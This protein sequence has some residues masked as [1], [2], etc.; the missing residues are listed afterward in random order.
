MGLS[1]SIFPIS[2]LQ[3]SEDFKKYLTSLNIHGDL[4]FDIIESCSKYPSL[5]EVYQLI[6]Q[7]GIIIESENKRIDDN[8]LK[9][10]NELIIHSLYIR[11]DEDINGNDFTM[12]YPKSSTVHDEIKTLLGIKSDLRILVKLFSSLSKECGSFIILSPYD[13][14]YIDKSK[15]FGEIWGQYGFDY[16]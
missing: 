10:G 15:S 14:Y 1:Y 5:S 8:E 6:D 4:N 3:Q 16:K 11:D 9:K 2:E 12:K 13:A 7:A